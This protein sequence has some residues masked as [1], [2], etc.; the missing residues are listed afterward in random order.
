MIK[1]TTDILIEKVKAGE[2]VTCPKC[3]KGFIVY[4]QKKGH[5]Y[6]DVYCNNP[7]CDAKV[8]FD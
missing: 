2:I 7:E 1:T 4:E 8:M 3:K 5:K 6:P